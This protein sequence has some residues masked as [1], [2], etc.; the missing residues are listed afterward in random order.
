VFIE[1]ADVDAG[2]V[3]WLFSG[4]TNT[5][6]DYQR[7][8]DSIER[9]MRACPAGVRPAGIQVIEPESPPPGAAW[10]KRIAESTRTLPRDD[11]V[12]CMVT[13]RTVI[14]GVLTAINWMRRPNYAFAVRSTF[15]E[16][17][18]WVEAER[19][20]PGR[21]YERLLAAARAEARERLAR[22]L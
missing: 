19:G 15:E 5:D 12:Y 4:A 16:A 17:V 13:E 22:A 6:D 3:V 8:L 18:A 20:H 2:E 14:R 21:S 1:S 7:Y 9:L 10:R 11:A